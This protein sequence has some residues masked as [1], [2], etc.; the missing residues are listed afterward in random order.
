[1]YLFTQYRWLSL[2]AAVMFGIISALLRTDDHPLDGVYTA[3]CFVLGSFLSAVAGYIGMAIATQA[4]SRTAEACKTS[5]TRGLQVSFAS[6]AVMGNGVVGLGIIGLSVL[7][8]VFSYAEG[9]GNGGAS[10]PFSVVCLNNVGGACI[11][12]STDSFFR[13]FNRL[14]GFGFGEFEMRERG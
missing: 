6:G 1:M 9:A 5:M 8:L 12:W 13:V 7:Y 3:L 2:W 4:N 10:D 11:T 14:A